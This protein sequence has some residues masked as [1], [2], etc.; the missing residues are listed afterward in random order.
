MPQ[1]LYTYQLILV[2]QI[3]DNPAI[4]SVQFLKGTEDRVFCMASTQFLASSVTRKDRGTHAFMAYRHVER[5]RRL[6]ASSSVSS[7]VIMTTDPLGWRMTA[8]MLLPPR[9]GA[10]VW[11]RSEAQQVR[12]G[13]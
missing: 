6:S 5:L 4:V 9:N 8:S 13:A 11:S 7:M 1:L 3:R 12:N 2:C 10:C